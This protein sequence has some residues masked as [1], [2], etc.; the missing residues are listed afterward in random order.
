MDAILIKKGEY[1]MKKINTF[2]PDIIAI[3]AV[4][5]TVVVAIAVS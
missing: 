1:N 3:S 2:I 5:L 4:M